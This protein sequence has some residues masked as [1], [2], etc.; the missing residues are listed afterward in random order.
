MRGLLTRWLHARGLPDTAARLLDELN[1]RL[2][3]PDRAIGPSYLMKPGA[4]RPEGLDLIW[5]TQILP[6]PEDHAPWHGH[7][8]R[9]G[10]RPGLPARSPRAVGPGSRLPA[11]GRPTV[12]PDLTLTVQETG[13]GTPYDR[14]GTRWRPWSP[15]PTWCG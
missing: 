6:L 11:A 3:E 1:S 2:G 12:T 4:A 15:C 8:R 13:P 7:R 9:G 5:R 14:P 10:V